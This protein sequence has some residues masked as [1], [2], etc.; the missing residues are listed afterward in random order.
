MPKTLKSCASSGKI[1]NEWSG[2][3]RCVDAVC[4]T[5][6]IRNEETGN[7]VQEHGHRGA[8][9]RARTTKAQLSAAE[10]QLEKNKDKFE[11]DIFNIQ[12]EINDKNQ[13]ID[14]LSASRDRRDLKIVSLGIEIEEERKNIEG[15]KKENDKIEKESRMRMQIIGR[16]GNDIEQKRIQIISLN[17][18]VRGKN[19]TIADLNEKRQ[20]LNNFNS[21]LT[22]QSN[23]LQE[24][25][26]KSISDNA[27]LV[28][29]SRFTENRNIELRSDIHNKIAENRNL[30]MQNAIDKNLNDQ[31]K[32]ELN[33][34]IVTAVEEK[35]AVERQL[36]QT[37]DDLNREITRLE[38]INSNQKD[39]I[40]DSM[41]EKINNRKQIV[42]LD[43]KLNK[44]RRAQ[45]I[46]L[47]RQ[48]VNN[49]TLVNAQNQLTVASNDNSQLRIDLEN[50]SVTT[51]TENS[52]LQSEINS[53]SE[54][55][56]QYVQMRDN[57]G[58][59]IHQS[60]NI[61][62]RLRLQRETEDRDS[63]NTQED[64]QD[65]ITRLIEERDEAI[66]N[67][68]NF[69]RDL[70]YITSRLNLVNE[71]YIQTASRLSTSENNLFDL[72]GR[73]RTVRGNLNT[74][75]PHIME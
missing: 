40:N 68:A 46:L 36:Q 57:L 54:Q 1:E 11:K 18:E 61:I 64:M 55:N 37:S 70:N 3:P 34:K 58:R 5:G 72:R 48:Q 49:Q 21:V 53:L 32:A 7:C 8:M 43:R 6:K 25:L 13:K 35:E 50:L 4:A 24:D 31:Q 14:D 45:R 12:E 52:N 33:S 16:L 65:R 10:K 29:Q 74:V 17:N 23:K 60:N 22:E 30:I 38:Q 26:R 2:N 9:Q 47:Q 73:L 28:L 39:Q 66:G 56:R 67:A 59:E 63:L 20:E 27:I 41:L 62:R 69:E 71:Q 42:E 51:R 75:L 15:L 44:Q 19:L